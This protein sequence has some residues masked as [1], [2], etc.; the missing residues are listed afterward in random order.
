MD[1]NNGI[2]RLTLRR[3]HR[4]SFSRNEALDPGLGDSEPLKYINS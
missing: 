2:I 1:K 4:I 3:S